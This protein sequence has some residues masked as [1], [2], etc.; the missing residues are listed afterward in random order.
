MCQEAGPFFCLTTL[1]NSAERSHPRCSVRVKDVPGLDLDGHRAAVTSR[2]RDLPHLRRQVC[3]C[4]SQRGLPL[5]REL[6][7]HP[8][9][10]EI[11]RD[12]HHQA[13]SGVRV[14]HY[15]IAIDEKAL[16][17]AIRKLTHSSEKGLVRLSAS[18]EFGLH[19]G[20]ACQQPAEFV[21]SCTLIWSV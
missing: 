10:D 18:D 8:S 14:E 6:Q 21:T 11:D 19:A 7:Y 15:A 5:C 1:A 20:Q 3:R 12:A 17:G 16:E 2:D 9:Y 4:C 13:E